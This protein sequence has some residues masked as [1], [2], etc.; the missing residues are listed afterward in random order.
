[1]NSNQGTKY[2]G[3]DRWGSAAFVV[4]CMSTIFMV[5]FST[6]AVQIWPYPWNRLSIL[7]ACLLP[8]VLV[9]IWKSP[10]WIRHEEFRKELFFVPIIIILGVLNILFSEARATTLKVMTLF[11]VSGIGVFGFT[12]CLLNTRYRQKMFFWLCWACLLAL[13]VHGTREYIDRKAVY[14]L[15]YNPIPAGCLLVLLF[16]GPFFLLSSS[17]RWLRFLQLLTVI[18]GIAVIVMIGKRGPI[19]AL[20]GMAFFSVVLLRG[21]KSWIILVVA[22]L[23]VGTGYKMRNHLPPQLTKHYIRSMSTLDRVENYALAGRIFVKKPLFGIGLHAPLT[24]YIQDYRPKVRKDQQYL[25]YVEN[26]KTFENIMLCGF[27]AM[28]GLF[29]I[30]YIALIIYILRNVFCNIKEKPEKRLQ[31]AMLLIPLTG[32]LIHSMTFDSLLFP[33]LNWLFH[34][35]LGLMANFTET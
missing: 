21:G 9:I 12:S 29:S 27:V 2:S 11:L 10:R 24:K 15:S 25:D 13:C 4:F 1:M 33:H 5:F 19:L 31:A 30:T 35:Y 3:W 34:S 22:L 8:L 28:G 7:V 17:S 14:L 23:L 18:W 26:Q 6:T 16:A 20:M 32:F